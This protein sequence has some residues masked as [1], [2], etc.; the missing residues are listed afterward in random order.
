MYWFLRHILFLDHIPFI[1]PIIRLL[2]KRTSSSLERDVFGLHF[3]NPVGLAAGLNQD[4]QF[5]S[6]FADLG[7]G[8]VEIG[9]VTPLPQNGN[10][11]QRFY[12]LPKDKGV[13]YFDGHANK[14]V[15]NLIENLKKSRP[16]TIIA[17]NISKNEVSEGEKITK[18]YSY[19]FTMLYDFVDM[20]IITQPDTTY[21]SEIMDDILETRLT[22][23]VYKPVLIKV[24][25]DMGHHQIDE[26][27]NYAQLYG[28][29]GIVAGS[30]TTKLENLLS[31]PKKLD[32]V[33]PGSLAGAP[34][35][36]ENLDLVKFINEETKGRL[37]IIA[38]GGIMNGEQAKQMLD[39]G[40][41]LVEICSG[42]IYKGP[43]LPQKINKYLSQNA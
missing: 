25:P 43:G 39:S 14:G 13:I 35:F 3:K 20:F 28:V 18:D 41:S 22:L 1:K 31:S 11:G 6:E 23:D 7:F 27:L 42:L 32:S 38:C 12:K 9:S 2:Y 4:G 29:D 19:C 26:I 37:P 15:K 33:G 34:L 24:S 16:D 10:T 5:T 8:F 30:G 40:A 21:L 17:A 36:K